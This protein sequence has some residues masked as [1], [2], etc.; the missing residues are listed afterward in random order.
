MREAMLCLRYEE[1]VRNAYVKERVEGKWIVVGE[2]VVYKNKQHI[3]KPWTEQSLTLVKNEKKK[4]KSKSWD[5][6]RW[7]RATM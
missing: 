2:R 5:Y 3:Q 1:R 4:K 7:G 6:N